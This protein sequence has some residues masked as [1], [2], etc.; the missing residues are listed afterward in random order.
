MFFKLPSHQAAF[1][2][3]HKLL[4]ALTVLSRHRIIFQTGSSR[5]LLVMVRYI[6]HTW[7]HYPLE[8]PSL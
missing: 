7:C 4:K 1:L 8:A 5:F 2:E 6:I 3:H